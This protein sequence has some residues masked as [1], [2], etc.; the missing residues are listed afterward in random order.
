MLTTPA[1]IDEIR[2][3]ADDVLSF[4]EAGREVRASL[5]PELLDHIHNM[6]CTAP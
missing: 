5:L 4:E 2:M 3:A 1:Q 6:L